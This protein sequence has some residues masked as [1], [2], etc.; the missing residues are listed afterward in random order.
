MVEPE[1]CAL[2]VRR[3]CELLAVN[4]NRLEGPGRSG[5]GT[6]DLE[7]ARRIDEIHLRFPEF[8]TRRTSQYLLREGWE[9]ASR[10]TVGGIMKAMGLAAIYRRPRT[11]LP[12]AGAKGYP[13]LLRGREVASPDEV[14]CAD[15][16]YIPMARGFA[17]LVAVMDWKTRAVLSWKL[18][19]TLDGTFCLA[20]LRQ[21]LDGAGRAPEIFNTDQGSQFTSR[22][23]IETLEHA[24]AK[25]SMDGQGRWMDNVFIE[26]LWRSVKHEGVYL[27][28]HENVHQLEAALEKWFNEYNHWKPHQALGYKTPWECYRPEEHPAWKSAARK[29]MTQGEPTSPSLGLAALRLPSLRSG[30]PPG[31]QPERNPCSKSTNNLQHQ[32]APRRPAE[33]T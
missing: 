33:L 17:Y 21:A 16:T 7:M 26:R 13:Y 31:G 19:N 10:R 2:S 11:S 22:A 3:Q 23:W 30:A 18:S 14:W 4:R 8:G 25:V 20:A 28:A 6:K 27:W 12:A 5:V 1:G 29:P 15:V 32:P 24:G 9:K